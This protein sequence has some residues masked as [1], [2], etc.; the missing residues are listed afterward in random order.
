MH[1]FR[2]FMSLNPHSVLD[3]KLLLCHF[4]YAK[5]WRRWRAPTGWRVHETG[6]PPRREWTNEI[7][8]VP[9]RHS[10]DWRG[11]TSR[12]NSCKLQTLWY[13]SNF[14]LSDEDH[15]G[16]IVLLCA[17][18]AEVLDRRAYGGRIEEILF[19]Y[20]FCSFHPSPLWAENQPRS[21]I[22]GQ[23]FQS[24][25]THRQMGKLALPLAR[26]SGTYPREA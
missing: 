3:G 13:N 20:F 8:A 19:P 9:P 21:A 6:K 17:P 23:L 11:W 26:S 22:E 4:P 10:Q 15:L 18:A 14:H 24:I 1:S 2:S 12:I 5:H 7:K 16:A 25:S